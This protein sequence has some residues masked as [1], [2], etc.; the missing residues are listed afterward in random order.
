MM[1]DAPLQN[2]HDQVLAHTAIDL[3]SK[4]SADVEG[5]GLFELWTNYKNLKNRLDNWSKDLVNLGFSKIEKG[6]VR[7]P[8]EQLFNIANLDETYSVWM[9][10]KMAKMEGLLSLFMIAFCLDWERYKQ[11]Y[12][13]PQP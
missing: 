9:G 2:F 8:P 3:L 1:H 6:E 7:I 11:N 13:Y 10:A 12:H 4:K 5:E